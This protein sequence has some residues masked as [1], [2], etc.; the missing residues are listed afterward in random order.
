MPVPDMAR[1]I[2]FYAQ[3]LARPGVAVAPTRHYF[4]CGATI[5][6]VVD[7]GEHDVA[8]RPNVEHFYFAVPDLKAAYERA[9]KA[10]CEWLEE[11]IRTRPW[12]EKSFYARDPFG[13]PICFVDEKTVFTG[14]EPQP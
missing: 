14:K 12:G 3:I 11:R 9:G 10:G 4:P 13:N 6:A 5:L 2:A 8:F 7:P 1:A